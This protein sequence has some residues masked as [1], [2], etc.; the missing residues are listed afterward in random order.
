MADAIDKAEPKI[1]ENGYTQMQMVEVMQ[2]F[3]S[4][5]YNGNTDLPFETDILMSEKDLKDQ[6]KGK[7]L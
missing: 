6:V 3:G 1:D 2:V 7:S 5:M 4:Y